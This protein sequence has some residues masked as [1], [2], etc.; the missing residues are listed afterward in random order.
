M[1]EWLEKNITTVLVLI[2][3]N[4]VILYTCMLRRFIRYI[5]Y[6]MTVRRDCCYTRCLQ[7]QGCQ[8]ELS[9]IRWGKNVSLL[10]KWV[11]WEETRIAYVFSRMTR[12]QSTILLWRKSQITSLLVALIMSVRHRWMTAKKY[13]YG[14]RTSYNKLRYFVHMYVKTCHQIYHLFYAGQM[15]LLSY[16]VSAE[17]GMPSQIRRGKNIYFL[18]IACVR[19]NT[20][21]ICVFTYD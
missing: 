8:Y 15:W 2:I 18:K 14:T 17:S 16:S 21:Y 11:V 5:I 19:G 12:P 1:A 9:Q 13:H 10:K 4:Y 20:Y 6:F 7:N 3:I